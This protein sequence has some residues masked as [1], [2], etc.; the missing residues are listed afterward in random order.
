MKVH[1]IFIVSP[2][3]RLMYSS[4]L[5]AKRAVIKSLHPSMWKV[6]LGSK[7]IFLT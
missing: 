2:G 7:G 6:E 4:A 5:S 1:T 3:L